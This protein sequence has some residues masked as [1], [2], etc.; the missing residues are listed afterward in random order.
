MAMSEMLLPEFDLEMANTRKVLERVPEEKFDWRP[1]AKSFAMGELAGH[2]ANMA[3]WMI[4]TLT[5]TSFD[6]LPNGQPVRMPPFPSVAAMLETFDNNVAQA[7]ALLAAASDEQLQQ[8]WTLLAN[9]AAIFTMPRTAVLRGMVFNHLVHH[10]GQL[11]IYL[12]MNDVPLP[13]LY[14]PSADEQ[15]M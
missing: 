1:H 2:L 9:G 12:R 7:R 15:V 11:T 10:R 13:A 8:P 5:T 14:G 4:Y 3:G 6:V